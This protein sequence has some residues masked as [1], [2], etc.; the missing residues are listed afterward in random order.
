MKKIIDF[1]QFFGDKLIYFFFLFKE[2]KLK[3]LKKSNQSK[4]KQK[5]QE[6]VKIKNKIKKKSKTLKFFEGNRKNS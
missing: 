1:C 6:K 2:K 4:T 3:S 5:I